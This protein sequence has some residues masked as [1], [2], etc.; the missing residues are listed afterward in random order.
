MKTRRIVMPFL[1]GL[2]IVAR[3]VA[4]D[5]PSQIPRISA[6]Y[7]NLSRYSLAMRIEI[8]AK[9]ESVPG[10]VL[11]ANSYRRGSDTLQEFGHLIVPVLAEGS[12]RCE[13]RRENDL[14]E[15]FATRGGDEV[16]E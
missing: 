3:A 13:P 12:P 5:D 15:R 4:A 14:C 11:H 8:Y 7:K 10:Q 16:S 1:A 2:L 6:Y 9:A